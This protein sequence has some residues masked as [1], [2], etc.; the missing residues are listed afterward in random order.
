MHRVS[1]ETVAIAVFSRAPVPGQAKTRL[2]PKLGSESAAKLQHAFLRKTLQTAVSAQVGPVSLWCAPN[3]DH[4]VFEQCRLD[5]KLSL[6]PQCGGDLG[7]RMLD[8]FE[9]LCSEQPVLLIGTDCPALTPEHLRLAAAALREGDDAVFLPVEDG[10]YV[11]IGLR[12]P[13]PS[14]FTDMPWGSA[15]VMAETRRRLVQQT[16]RWREPALLWDV[17]NPEDI[18]RLRSSR[19]MYEWFEDNEQ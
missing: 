5:F 6:Q 4:P 2:I 16:M 17:D 3:C 14:L 11:L 15:E 13:V 12:R 1:S 18:D 8:V 9:K 10:G 19:L 7:V